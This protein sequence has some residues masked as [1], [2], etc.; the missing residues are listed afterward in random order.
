MNE[1]RSPTIRDSTSKY[2]ALVSNASKA[3]IPI[4]TSVS[5][6]AN[7]P[8]ST[9]LTLLPARLLGVDGPYKG[10]IKKGPLLTPHVAKVWPKS[11]SC[12]CKPILD[13]TS[14]KPKI[15]IDVLIKK[16]AKSF[17]ANAGLP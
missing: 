15:P 5:S 8:D 6:I 11:S 4:L 7:V 1:Y 9:E 3:V 16:R 2:L 14:K 13:A 17:A 12:R 10:I